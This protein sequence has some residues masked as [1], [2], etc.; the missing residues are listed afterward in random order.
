MIIARYLTRQIFSS[1]IAIAF[2][3]VVTVVIGRMLSYLGKAA[4]GELD[5]D[6]VVL[7]MSYRLPEFVQLTLPL[8]LVLGV[9]LTYGRLY[10]E[11]EMT[12]L[13]ACG[14]SKIRLFLMT[15]IPAAIFTVIV[16]YLSLVL[17]PWGLANTDRLM[18][19]QEELTEFDVLM[20]G[21]FQSMSRGQRTTYAESVQG[22]A[23]HNVFMHETSDNRATMAETAITEQDE[24]GQRYVL[25]E[26]GSITEGVGIGEDF[27]VTR[28]REMG[29]RIP[30]RNT[31]LDVIL[32]E[33]A[34]PTAELLGADDPALQAELQWRLSLVILIPVLMLVVVPLSRVSPR[35][36][37][38]ARL[39]PAIMLYTLYFALL[40]SGRDKLSE[41]G[42]PLGI[43][44]IHALFLAIGWL[45]FTDRLPR[46][47]R[48][49]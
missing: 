7:L 10:A 37:R 23:I 6:V 27:A 18:A 16:G 48:K 43:W 12:V 29:V 11:S 15:L 2:I 5:M 46:F 36:G 49:G 26:Q 47:L 28:F 14:M 33:K 21:L 39:V 41:G 9:L 1:T 24:N 35:E 30:P 34:M 25:M 4:Q 20:P 17:T 44:W 3:M 42:M 32:E 40:L 38:F 8:A 22:G 13:I 45:V 31:D 19:E